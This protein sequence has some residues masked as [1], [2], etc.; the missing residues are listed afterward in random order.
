M[1]KKSTISNFLANCIAYIRVTLSILCLVIQ[2]P[3]LH[4][5]SMIFGYTPERGF[6][7][8][9]RFAA[10]YIFILNVKVSKKGN[11]ELKNALYVCNHRMMIDPLVLLRHCDAYIVS[12]A[13]VADYPVL[14]SGAKNTGVIFVQRD[15]RGSRAAIKEKIGELLE[16]GDSVAIFPEG[17]VNLKDTTSDFSK[18]SFDQAASVGCA[19]VPVALD[20]ADRTVYWGEDISLMAHF[21]DVFRRRKLVCEIVF[22]DPIYSNDPIELMEKSRTFID[23]ELIKMRVKWDSDPKSSSR[24]AARSRA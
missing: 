8:R 24:V 16:R 3:I 9:R 23:D 19:V 4:I 20:F 18:G 15:H 1:A 13:E 12:K 6:K 5:E 21:L 17:T 2:V 11:S 10:Y 7:Y 22:G 14:G